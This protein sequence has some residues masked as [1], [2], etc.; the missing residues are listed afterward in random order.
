MRR[1]S[2][3]QGEHAVSGEPNTAIVTVLGSCISVC[4]VDPVR[5]IGGMN[6]FL[7]GAPSTGAQ[8]QASDLQRYGVHAMELLINALMARGCQRP[9]IRAHL[10]GGA[11]MI[12]RLG[13]IGARN[14]DFARRFLQTEG[15]LIRHEDV[16][17]SHARR[18]EFHPFEGR[19]RCLKVREPVV[20][21]APQPLRGLPSDAGEL[22]LF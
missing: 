14:I 1:I 20:V 13:D 4:L 6:H 12:A 7:L 3:V 19:S 10:Y 15:F 2:I 17:G 16:G 22:E 11:T 21:Q 9:D 18:V 8:A 5:R